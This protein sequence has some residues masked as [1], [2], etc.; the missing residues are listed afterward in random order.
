MSDNKKFVDEAWNSAHVLRDDGLSYPAYTEQIT[1]LL[2]HLR[3]PDIAGD[4]ACA[5]AGR[6]RSGR[7]GFCPSGR[8]I[9]EAK[10]VARLIFPI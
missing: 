1:F 9:S 6:T 7:G 5:G 8:R 4:A 3:R 10:K 2:F